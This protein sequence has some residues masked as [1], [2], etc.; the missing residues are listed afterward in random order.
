MIYFDR[1]DRYYNGLLSKE[2][3]D[4]FWE[5]MDRNEA[6]RKEYV[7]YI[8]GLSIISSIGSGSDKNVNS[9]LKY[10]R[11]NNWLT[12]L[13][14]VIVSIGLLTY[15]MFKEKNDFFNFEES[16]ER[17][18]SHFR[19][20]K[21]IESSS[22]LLDLT[23][24]TS[25]AALQIALLELDDILVTMLVEGK[26]DYNSI[27]TNTIISEWIALQRII[28][29]GL[30]PSIPH[31]NI[32]SEVLKLTR[33]QRKTKIYQFAVENAITLYQITNDE[34]YL[35]Q[36][37]YYS[38]C[39]KIA[40]Y[41]EK[42][43][44]SKKLNFFLPEEEQKNLQDLLFNIVLYQKQINE[45][46]Q[47][48]AK[49]AKWRQ[50][51]KGLKGAYKSLKNE[52]KINYPEYA[53]Q[54]EIFKPLTVEKIRNDFLPNNTALVEYFST[55]DSWYI[56]TLTKYNLH[57]E[58]VERGERFK[59]AFEAVIELVSEQPN[60]STYVQDLS[61]FANDSHILYEYLLKKSLLDVQK[62]VNSLLIIPDEKLSYFPF[63]LLLTEKP[64]NDVAMS[65]SSIDMPYLFNDYNISYGFS[66]TVVNL[67]HQNAQRTKTGEPAIFAPT[68]SS[69]YI[70]ENRS[71]HEDNLSYLQC[72]ATEGERINGLISGDIFTGNLASIQQ[73]REV[74]P[75]A[76]IL[77]LA[78]HAC[79]DEENEDG[80]KIFF[81]DTYLTNEDLNTIGFNADLVVLSACDM[82]LENLIKG[83]H[84]ISLSQNFLHAG[85]ASTVI[86]L[87]SIEDCTSSDLM[88]NF[89]QELK[90]GE[91]K[92]TA[93]KNAKLDYLTGADKLYQHPYFWASFV[94]SGN[95]NSIETI[96]SESSSLFLSLGLS[97][98]FLLFLAFF[99]YHNKS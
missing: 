84:F 7:N 98:V 56:F 37:F 85:A 83:E 58:E 18:E 92:S 51:L 31:T 67:T 21:D 49:I 32:Q 65:Y 44:D 23:I 66:A 28:D 55:E 45:K 26:S 93:L 9:I 68:F 33:S 69:E 95:I 82:S 59:K 29:Y 38:E 34:T 73:F 90:N 19:D 36:A 30:V 81:A 22:L 17:G 54:T 72:N 14:L 77:H 13:F 50:T 41:T 76:P 43:S 61:N 25:K 63:E 27:Q 52:L 15:Y 99:W 60:P 48:Y 8:N 79:V 87:W 5:D 46:Q 96:E 89:Y 12:V 75:N 3:E 24:D 71:C 42:V 10:G 80:N 2:E 62:E 78:T 64:K 39:S 88:V 57:V 53:E 86:S 11:T 91:N 4:A 70:A 20:S 47:N 35:E 1:I 97:S 16:L 94:L 40:N 74:A 6:M